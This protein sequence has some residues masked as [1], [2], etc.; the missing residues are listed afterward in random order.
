MCSTTASTVCTHLL[1]SSVKQSPLLAHTKLQQGTA[2]PDAE[3]GLLR[4]AEAGRAP[5]SSG[6]PG[7]AELINCLAAAGSSA[8]AA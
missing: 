3:A 4:P 1:G 7:L 8:A 6:I 5:G 2:L